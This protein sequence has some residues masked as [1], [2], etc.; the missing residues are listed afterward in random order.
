MKQCSKCRHTK[1]L[2][3]F[4]INKSRADN[5]SSYCKLCELARAKSETNKRRKYARIWRKY[6]PKKVLQWAREA[7]YKKRYKITIDEYNILFAG[8]DGYC[9]ICGRHQTV[10]S[11]RLAVD[12]DHITGKI[13]GLLCGDCSCGMGILKEHNLQK[14]LDYLTKD[15]VKI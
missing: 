8:Q 4:Y 6:N 9:A 1:P 10:L 12:H 11:K 5:H 13:R 15:K 3:Q 14:A 7:S 2:D